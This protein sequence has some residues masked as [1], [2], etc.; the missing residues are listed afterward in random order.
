MLSQEE[1]DAVLN[2]SVGGGPAE[3]ADEPG[4]IPVEQTVTELAQD[5]NTDLSAD[6]DVLDQ[7]EMDALGEIGNISMGSAST[8][9]SELLR[10][11]VSITSPKVNIISQETLYESFQVPYIVIQ[12]EF[13]SGLVGFNILVIRLKDAMVMSNLMM[14]GEGQVETDEISEIEI[15]AASEAMNQMI[16][17]ASTSLATLFGRPVN[18]SPPI[19][20]VL[21][22]E[23]RSKFT[24]PIGDKVVVVSFA[25][26]IG[27]LVDTEIM[28]VLSIST[29]KREAALLWHNLMGTPLEGED[30]E[31]Q[32]SF[33]EV[34][35]EESSE[36]WPSE[37]VWPEIEPPG[38]G[39]LLQT[40][41]QEPAAAIQRSGYSP[42]PSQAVPA[43]TLSFPGLSQAEQRK[44]ELL[45]EVP[46][47]ISVILGRTKKPIKEVLNLTPG[48]I[49]ELT[50]LVD[51]PVEVLV[52]GTLVA[53]GEV[54]VVNE[55]FG[56]R[57]ISI[58]S[59][60]ERLKQLRE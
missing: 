52:N 4:S 11:K 15:S 60:E 49:V 33:V 12:V 34:E 28:Q 39:E 21:N 29:A 47:K 10:Q 20:T 31:E 56:V 59:P 37:E 44:M 45:L 43:Q 42:A 46:L 38:A 50:S 18:I 53:R 7:S 57:V 5:E 3:T 1:I 32:P 30:S 9:L 40:P 27:D 8:T 13:K 36:I 17:T 22:N 2:A 54:V 51:E 35:E 14:G 23:D 58:I 19:T 48:A 25:L 26:K 16:G 24:L 6:S 41:I 55:N